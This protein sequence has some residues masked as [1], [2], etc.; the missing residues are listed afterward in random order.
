MKKEE[1]GYQLIMAEV[2]SDLIWRSCIIPQVGS[3]KQ[4]W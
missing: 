3:A 1:M 2:S 4:S